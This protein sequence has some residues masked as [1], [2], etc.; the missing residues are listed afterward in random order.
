M[1]IEGSKPTK[2][3][4]CILLLLDA[5]YADLEFSK[6]EKSKIV[7]NFGKEAFER[8]E[9]YYDSL[10]DY[11]RL[12]RIIQLRKQ[13]YPGPQGK[14]EVLDMLKSHFLADGDYRKLE[15][16]QYNFLKKML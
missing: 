3:E 9:A 12:D 10:G 14:N 16:S 2:K 8:V 7:E 1:L 15:K 13:F 11:K 6:D 4:F 5:S